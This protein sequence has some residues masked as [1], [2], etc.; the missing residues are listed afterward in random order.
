MGGHER[1]LSRGRTVNVRSLL[2]Q[3][4]AVFF[5]GLLTGLVVLE[6][7]L[8]ALGWV[9][10]ARVHADRR[11]A[12][13]GK[14]TI[15][16]LGDSYTC[17]VGAPPGRGYPAQL[18]EFLNAA[19][20]GGRFVV[21]NR[22]EPAQNTGMLLRSLPGNLDRIRPDIVVVMSGLNNAWNI[23]GYSEYL[24]QRGLESRFND[25]LHHVSVFRLAK[26]LYYNVA[27][28]RQGE[29]RFPWVADPEMEAASP[30]PSASAASS[31]TD[32]PRAAEPVGLGP[33]EIEH[34][35]TPQVACQ[36]AGFMRKGE[37]ALSQGNPRR[38][39]ALL[40]LA[41]LTDPY[42]GGYH[43]RMARLQEATGDPDAA[44]ATLL[45][46]AR[47]ARQ[48]EAVHLDLIQ[49]YRRRGRADLALKAA[50]EGVK[51]LPGSAL[52]HEWVG[53]LCLD[54][55]DMEGAE[56]AF[57][58]A[59]AIFPDSR[60]AGFLGGYY[61]TCKKPGL[62]VK[63]LTAAVDLVPD[64]ATRTTI[65]CLLGIL[66]E[67]HLDKE[68]AEFLAHLEKTQP[69]LARG[70]SALKSGTEGT[71]GF[72]QW[73]LDDYHAVATICRERN[74]ALLLSNYPMGFEFASGGRAV[75]VEAGRLNGVPVVDNAQIFQTLK[76][77]GGYFAPD[78]H[79]NERGYGVLARNVM[80]G[81]QSSGLLSR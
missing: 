19:A 18:E 50:R 74:V 7:F 31:R 60:S 6:L 49:A 71:A 20:G 47:L 1:P 29:T 62:A 56:A 51:A 45:R 70:V 44:L 58:A 73:V 42:R 69:A 25:A 68:R 30:S 78:G 59:F 46:G 16:C 34:G 26:M 81:L 23:K 64:D 14:T 48:S 24:G 8:R 13:P 63:Y 22:G 75:I 36:A 77:R 57:L 54:A 9:Y 72:E 76:D 66:D 11:V 33:D 38:A 40:R 10:A 55:Q 79:C 35:V 41:L 39:L 43:V 80:K 37:E 28:R 4:V 12:Q 17:G 21:V 15:L 2:G 27:Q 5:L 53:D 32:A 3:R 67:Y 52:L 65:P 61:K